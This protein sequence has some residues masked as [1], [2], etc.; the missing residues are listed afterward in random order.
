MALNVAG[1]LAQS[2]QN[3]GQSIGAPIQ[4]FGEG[5]GSML[6]TRQQKQREQEEQNEVK[7]LLQKY[8]NNP[9]QLNA[10][11]TNAAAEGNDQLSKVFF[12][13]AKMAVDKD[14]KNA[15]RGVQG[16]LSA[17]TQAASRGVP[18]A[19]LRE[20]QGSVLT[21]GG[22]NE[23]INK[24]Y[25]DGLELNKKLERETLQGSP[26]TVFGSYDDGGNF[27]VDYTV[28]FKPE[29]PAAGKP[30]QTIEREDGSVSIIHGTTG[31]LISTLPPTGK[32]EGDQE[33][34]ANL[35]G[36]TV[37]LISEVD[38][39]KDPSFWESGLTGQF[40]SNVGGRDAHDREK[41]LL[42]LR[43]QLGFDQIN[44][45]KR[46]AAESGA[47]GT[48]LGQISNIEFMSLQSTIDAIYVSMT[49]EAQNEAL[50]NIKRHL[51]TVQKLASGVAPIDTIQW[52]KPEYKA[53]GYHKDP[54]TGTVFYAPEGPNGT[55][56]KLVD[57]KFVK[58]GA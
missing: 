49:A 19:D 55:R 35:I 25:K 53:V 50:E 13:A 17:I 5:L 32:G 20:A 9:E 31:E 27:V 57:G 42:S 18:L 58:I 34:S 1:M 38:K 2:G 15:T 4:R 29:T 51:Q 3:I 36:Q 28:P 12:N 6:G 43:A 23:Q 40:L 48:G 56:Y 45:M 26:G 14:T 16:G 8:A 39:L 46:L 22:T 24:A 7:Q 44:E 37:H 52:E 41:D 10:L 33:A 54:E 11:G 47:S 21:L 30:V